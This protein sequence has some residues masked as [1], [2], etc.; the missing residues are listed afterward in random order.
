M[1]ARIGAL[2]SQ[3]EPSAALTLANATAPDNNSTPN[4][5]DGQFNGTGVASGGAGTKR[6]TRRTSSP[7]KKVKSPY[8]TR[9]ACSLC[10]GTV[11]RLQD[12]PRHNTSIHLNAKPWVCCGVPIEDAAKYEIS[13]DAV[14]IGPMEHDTGAGKI[15]TI[16]GC[17]HTFKRKD[18]Y[19]HHLR[20]VRYGRR[21]VGNPHGWYHKENGDKA[22]RFLVPQVSLN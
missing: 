2:A 15:M 5:T 12:L 6:G 3:T 13:A 7:R 14:A 10:S 19:M 9:Y 22:R 17:G 11:S 20:G 21:C 1:P 16:G 8:A 18:T 4:P